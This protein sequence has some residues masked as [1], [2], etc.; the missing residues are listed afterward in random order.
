MIAIII[1]L[2]IIIFILYNKENFTGFRKL[3]IYQQY[4][5]TDLFPF[6]PRRKKRVCLN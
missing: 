5:D 6:L 2:L 4:L 1:I 3:G